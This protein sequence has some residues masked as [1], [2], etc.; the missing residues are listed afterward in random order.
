MVF[1]DHNVNVEGYRF[2][3]IYMVFSDIA[4][5]HTSTFLVYTDSWL[6]NVWPEFTTQA[7]YMQLLFGS[8]IQM[9]YK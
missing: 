1:G 6:Y 2:Q 7:P 3:I 9:L 4:T 8:L 5:F